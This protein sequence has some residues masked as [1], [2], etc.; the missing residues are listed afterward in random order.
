MNLNNVFFYGLISKKLI[1][2]K[3]KKKNRGFELNREPMLFSERN[4]DKKF[5]LFMGW[6]VSLL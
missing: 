6:R 2:I 3:L 5:Y 4:G 1:W